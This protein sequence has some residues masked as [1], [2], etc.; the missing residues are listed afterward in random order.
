MGKTIS[1][2]ILSLHSGKDVKAD[3][4]II[5]NVD[6][7]LVQDGT[8]PLTIKEFHN[9]KFNTLIPHH[10]LLFIDHASPS[11]RK[12]LS[13]AH[14]ILRSFANGGNAKLFDVGEGV[15]HQ[16]VAEKFVKPGNL[17][18]GADSHTCTAGAMGA[19]ATGM[20]STDIAIAFGTGKVWLKVPQTIKIKLTGQIQKGVYSKDVMLHIIGDIKADGATYKAL[21][22][23]GDYIHNLSFEQRLTLTNMAV[24]AGAK[25]GIIPT[26]DITKEY[27]KKHNR[28]KD[29][30]EI[31]ADND[32]IYEQILEYDVSK[33]EPQIS[34]PHTVDNVKNISEINEDIKIDQ[35]VIG[36]CTN[37]RLEDLKIA[38]DIMKGHKK[39]KNIRCLI[40]PAS[41]EV[42]KEAVKE[43]F[44]DIFIDFGATIIN[45][46]C[47]P[48]VGVH[49][50]I[51]ADGEKV[52]ST[53]N[54]N[55][56][57]RM[58]NP[59]AEIYLSSPA[60]AAAT[61]ITGKITDPRNF[62]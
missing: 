29:Y 53:Q 27:L 61:A 16:I 39:H 58:G 21:E 25:T 10:S 44:I 42:Y 32:A 55:F 8:G 37:G 22:F 9:L 19:F 6:I 47:G 49:A 20:G 23:D 59:L 15:S 2:K 26:D 41:K 4:F 11:P 5:T 12:E 28:E 60:T 18:V 51:L 57:G 3:D 24:E 36:T 46:G 62:I 40:V 30:I 14:N 48:C 56:K 43:G 31:Y 1:E 54:R 33:I 35:V 38:A 50:G 17:V 7:A 52:L 13:N 34:F 45:P